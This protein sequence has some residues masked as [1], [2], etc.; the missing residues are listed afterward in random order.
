M[1][2]LT[3]LLSTQGHKWVPL[4]CWGD[5]TAL[6]LTGRKSHIKEKYQDFVLWGWHGLKF[7]VPLRGTI[8]KTINAL[9]DTIFLAQYTPKGNTK[10]PAVGPLEIEH[11]KRHQDCFCNT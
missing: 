2:T 3:K 9:T 6:S 1:L 5:L 4:I 11:S 7:F 8:S 10:A